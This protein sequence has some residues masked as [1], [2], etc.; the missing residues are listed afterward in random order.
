MVM[1]SD[2]SETPGVC[3]MAPITHQHGLSPVGSWPQIGSCL[4]ISL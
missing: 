3:I 4:T 2:G 1:V